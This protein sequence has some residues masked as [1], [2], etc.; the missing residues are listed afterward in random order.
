MTEHILTRERGFYFKF[1]G[2]NSSKLEEQIVPQPTGHLLTLSPANA[3]AKDIVMERP[4]QLG[5]TPLSK[6]QNEEWKTSE[7]NCRQIQSLHQCIF[8]K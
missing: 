2:S 4:R 6:R 5:Y 7:S 3:M 1:W 8:F